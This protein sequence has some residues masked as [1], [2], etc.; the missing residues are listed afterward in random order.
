[1]SERPNVLWFM[2]EDCSPHGGALG[3]GLSRTPT[4]DRLVAGGVSWVNAFS[5]YPVCAPSRFALLTGVHAH[6]VAPANQMRAVAH[7]PPTLRTYPEVLSQHGYYCTN[8]PKT[9]YNCDVDP[10]R[11][12]HDSSPEA[13][14]R[15]APSGM[16]FFAVFN[17][18]GT[19]ESAL[20]HRPVG[21]VS[22]DRITVPAYLPDTAEIRSDLAHCHSVVEAM[23]RDFA[24]RLA[25]LAAAGV[26]EDTVVVYSSDHG[27]VGPWSK[28][29]C[30]DQGLRVP[31]VIFAPPKWQH[32]LPHPPGSRVTE[33]VTHIDLTPTLIELTGAEAPS[34]MQGRSLLGPAGRGIAF[35][36]R[37]RMDERIDLVRTARDERYRYLRNYLPHRPSGQH[38][39]YAWTAVGYQSW[40]A[41]AIAGQLTDAQRAFFEPRPFEELYDTVADPDHQHNLV[42]DPA[43]RARLDGLRVALDE[44]ILRTG[45]Q[46]FIPEGSATQAH[47]GTAYYPLAAVMDLA[48]LAAGR[49]L[50]QVDRLI[51]GLEDSRE[52][53]RFWAAQGLLMLAVEVQLGDHVIA[54]LRECAAHDPSVHVRV[55]ASEAL[56][57]DDDHQDE[58]LRLLVHELT[59]TNDPIIQLQV[60]NAL[61]YA[62]AGVPRDR[63]LG[64]DPRVTVALDAVAAHADDPVAY[65]GNAA[66][67]LT[68][69]LRGDYTPATPIFDVSEPS[70]SALR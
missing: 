38:Q 29:Y 6:S 69:R 39:G 50:D 45:D 52:V 64:G 54:V 8:N 59:T 20:F 51:A 1:M 66:R 3:D 47:L 61:T 43:Y 68:H 21:A 33:P 22:P 53:L 30:H 13:H 63:D 44:F 2:S 42:H 14:W 31:L 27:G 70:G 17:S 60:L 28:R 24:D 62:G 67:Y 11:I 56:S 19:H 5:T 57:H 36:C 41:L 37:D 10:S 4:I 55:V 48:A 18:N 12:W 25:E 16:P 65:V 23:D 7:L 9:D 49:D 40:E 46:G 34:T 32:V 35:G 58:A 26:A 15:H